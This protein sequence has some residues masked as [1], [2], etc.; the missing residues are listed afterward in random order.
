MRWSKLSPLAA[1]SV[2]VLCSPTAAS[3]ADADI[4]REWHS[5]VR[6][7]PIDPLASFPN[8]I[9]YASRDASRGIGA[10]V[11]GP[12]VAVT[13]AS[14]TTQS[15]N[16]LFVSPLNPSILL[17]S[18]NSSDW[19][20]TQIFGCSYWVSTNGGASWTGST[21]GAGGT[22]RGDPSTAINRNGR[23]FI[24]GIAQDYGQF[25][26]RSDDNGASWTSA[27]LAPGPFIL[28][29]N[30]MTVDNST[31]SPNVGN[32]YSSWTNI[33]GGAVDG[34]IELMRSTDG[35]V[36][37]TSRQTLSAAILAGSHNQGVNIQT[38]PGGQVYVVWTIYDC[39]P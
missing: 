32:L 3:A 27:A 23:M 20:V 14:N 15:E 1:F 21:Q 36:T 35:G 33:Q 7:A 38:G 25:V 31:A 9:I 18:N 17:N 19:P 13:T 24:G 5:V 4:P 37:W 10:F 6:V 26:A 22:N 39:W 29:K 12:D 2:L 16:S 8:P 11:D 30:H 34:E 28:D